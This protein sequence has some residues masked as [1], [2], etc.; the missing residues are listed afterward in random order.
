M[1]QYQRAF[2]LKYIAINFLVHSRGGKCYAGFDYICMVCG[3]RKTL[4]KYTQH[5]LME[6]WLTNG[7][8]PVYCLT[9]DL[10][11]CLPYR[12][13]TP[14]M[15][16]LLDVVRKIMCVPCDPEIVSAA[17]ELIT[18]VIKTLGN[19]TRS[20]IKAEIWRSRFIK[21]FTSYVQNTSP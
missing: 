2:T 21:Y 13:P 11:P 12:V 6:L 5:S 19:H 17:N 8:G 20:Q 3:R 9:S 16:N 4:F 10:R 18:W 14:C 1:F 15:F 7:N